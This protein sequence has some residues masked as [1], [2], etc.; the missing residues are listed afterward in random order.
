MYKRQEFRGVLPSIAGLVPDLT[1]RP[2]G[3]QFSPRCEFSK[4]DCKEKL[5]TLDDLGERKARCFYPVNRE[6]V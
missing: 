4:D 6:Q 5:P 2:S 1:A 3:C